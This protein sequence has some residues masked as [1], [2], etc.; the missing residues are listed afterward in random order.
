MFLSHGIYDRYTSVREKLDNPK[1]SSWFIK[2]KNFTDAAYPG[3]QGLQ[4]NNTIGFYHVPACDW[5]GDAKSGPPKCSGFYHDQMQ[6]PNH[7]N[8]NGRSWPAYNVDG[9]CIEQ[10]RLFSS[11][12]LF[13]D[14]RYVLYSTDPSACSSLFLFS[15]TMYARCSAIAERRTRAEK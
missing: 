8:P 1:Y 13:F 2:F 10:V 4:E 14:S 7:A 15:P 3:G 11:F 9:E 12:V 6:S 5:Y